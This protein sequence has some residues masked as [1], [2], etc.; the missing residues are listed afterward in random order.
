MIQIAMKKVELL[1]PAGGFEELISAVQAG[2][3]AVYI[4]AKEFSAR[5]YAKN[6]SQD[7]LIR[8]IDYCHQR[9]KKIYLAINTLIYDEEIDKAL[10]LLE[11]AYKEGIDAAIVQDFGLLSII[12]K[13]FAD[14]PIHASTQMTV[15]NL[16]G[17][18][19]L[20]RLG[21]KRVVLARELNI[22][23]IKNI[24]EN[25][26]IEVEV[27]VHGAL[28]IS[29][30]GQ[31]LFSSILF[32]RS[33]NRG[34]C[35]QVCRLY[36]NLLGKN[37]EIVDRGYLLSPKDICLLD[38]IPH[39]IKAGVDSFKI[40]GRLKDKYYVYTVTSV[41]RKYIDMYYQTGK[42]EID[43]E[44][45]NK[46]FLV[47]NRGNFSK[48]YL[49]NPSYDD[50]IFKLAPNNTGLLIG[51]FYF[52]NSK[53][54]VKTDYELVNGDVIAFRNEKF[55]EIL[56]EINNNISKENDG[57]IEVDI[58]SKR[59]KIL[60]GF[61]KGQVFLVKSKKLEE[62]IDQILK[63]ERKFRKVDFEV[64]VREGE[65]IKAVA[66]TEFYEAHAIG[67]VPQEAKTKSTTYQNIFDSFS[68]LGGTIFEMGDLKAY[69]DDN[70]FV[71]VSD[72]NCLR[73]E[74]IEKLLEAIT[75][76]FKR[77]LQKPFGLLCHFEED[78][79]G[80][81]KA[82]YPKFSFVVDSFSQYRKVKE[83]LRLYSL[84]NSEIYVPYNL[85]FAHEFSEND[86]VYFDRITHDDDLKK[87]DLKALK[88]R[89][90]KKV[91]IRNL[92]QYELLK[93]QFE[94]YFDYSFNIANSFA[95]DFVKAL[96]AKRVCLS[97]ELSKKQIEKVWKDAP[98]TIEV[99]TVVVWRIPLMINKLKFFEKGS[100]LQDRK[101]EL[102]KLISTQTMKNE[103]LNPA[104]LYIDDKNVPSDVIRFDF[105]GFS[106]EEIKLIFAKYFEGK[107]LNTGI[108]LTKGY[109]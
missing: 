33:G 65:N 40:E 79:K 19:V 101:G 105:T 21:V 29:Y 55:D 30:S 108:K 75:C 20:S 95:V 93:D 13:E 50:L 41:Y 109:Y 99:E 49:G 47:F 22:D 96:G 107:N 102:L 38:Y 2:A 24:K 53:L 26:D 91:L 77:N 66:R 3:D 35:A 64:T 5:A 73:K 84:E 103:I 106:E 97:C 18:K 34:Q 46:L 80:K 92:G 71:R 45:K 11:L 39:L 94:L 6:F 81:T 72:L 85:I 83:I 54:F 70:L 14:L 31:C 87:I 88:D 16:P 37:K 104:I 67:P 74:L 62:E 78:Q 1:S 8:A 98:E 10:K 60:E 69:I 48:G 82:A 4:G 57:K 32:K 59:K 15:H 51:S 43:K 44:D 58:D 28:C 7:E 17:A 61:S 56:L 86:V 100:Y 23:E 42:I 76:H 36:Y 9:G 52:K 63:K 12:K 25:T 90:I 89:G 27:F 68:K